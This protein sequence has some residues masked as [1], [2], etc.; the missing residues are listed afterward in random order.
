[1][2]GLDNFSESEFE[3]KYVDFFAGYS[4]IGSFSICVIEFFFDVI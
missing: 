3:K 2:T 1:M 4:G